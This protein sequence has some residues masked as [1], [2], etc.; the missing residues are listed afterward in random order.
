MMSDILF[1][2]G[3]FSK[4]ACAAPSLALTSRSVLLLLDRPPLAEGE[5]CHR[6][7]QTLK[8]LLWG[9]K[10]SCNRWVFLLR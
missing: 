7:S 9:G 10:A 1:T 5:P 2:A 3:T 6:S 8:S 4:V